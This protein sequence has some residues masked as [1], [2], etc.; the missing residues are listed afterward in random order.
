MRQIRDILRLYFE[1]RLSMRQIAQSTG[2]GLA[3]VSDRIHRAE[4]AGLQWP[5]AAELDDG[6]LEHLLYPS[7][8]GRP[9]VVRPEP[10]WAVV[11]AELRRKGVTLELL[12]IEY[13]RAQPDGYQYSWFC[14]RYHRWKQRVDPV[15]RQTYRAGEKLFVDYAGQTLPIVEPA[16]GEV[17]QAVLFVA[18][19]AASNYTYA[20]LQ[21]AADLPS[22]IG[23]HTRALEFFRGAPALVISDNLKAGVQRASWYEPTLNATY[24]EWAAY[25]GTAIL[26]ARPRQPR[27]RAKVE[28][29]VQVA[30]RW[31]LAVL[32]HERI[33]SIAAGNALLR[34]LLERLNARPFKKLPGSRRTV[35]EA[36]DQPALRALPATPYEFAQW[37][38][39]KVSIDYHVA[40]DGNCYS[41][42]YQLVGARVDIRLTAHTVEVLRGG[43]RVA[44]HARS[45]GRGAYQTDPH[46]RPHSHQQYLEW[47][48][49]RLIRWA[50]TIGPHTA[51]LVET[52]LHERPHP[53]QGYRACLGILR[54]GK[55]YPPARVEAAAARALASHAH[56]YRSLKSI[57]ERGLEQL[58]LELTPPPLARPP[59]G[60]VRGAAYFTDKES[61]H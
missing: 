47:S 45:L 26:P 52:I 58:P 15:L 49:S 3:S 25:Y 38:Q 27:D 31:L 54:L 18:V 57:L 10:D 6:G 56:S 16:T 12:W 55:Y 39:A 4:A 24:A 11:D 44:S 2:V 60:H 23:G 5:V 17:R 30:E 35:F 46:H 14:E 29:G 28:A 40:V 42:P 59:H 20:E 9:V 22:W 36:L 41:V 1:Q 50:T 7:V 13:K 61:T 8:Q 53:E 19:L 43:R 21:A 34:P 33:T 48:P 37:K 51:T 32:R